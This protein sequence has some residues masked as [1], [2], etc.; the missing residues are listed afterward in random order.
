MP[1]DEPMTSI[2][3]ERWEDLANTVVLHE[4]QRMPP[5]TVVILIDD[6]PL[7]AA[8]GRKVFAFAHV[9]DKVGGVPWFQV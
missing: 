3:E 8:R 4:C 9:I 7:L 2:T 5:T 1:I 6:I